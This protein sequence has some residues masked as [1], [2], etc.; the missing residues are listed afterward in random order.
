MMD[1]WEWDISPSVQVLHEQI[2]M[3]K[4]FWNRLM[5]EEEDVLF[6]K[7]IYWGSKLR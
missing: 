5:L 3:F 2:Y 1:L 4:W 7:T 6:Q